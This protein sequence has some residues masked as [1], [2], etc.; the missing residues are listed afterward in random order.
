[1]EQSSSGQEQEHTRGG[2]D[3]APGFT[4]LQLV[5]ALNEGGVERGAIEISSAITAAGGRALVASAG[6]RLEQALRRAGGELIRLPGFDA[7]NPLKLPDFIRAIREI[8]LAEKVDIV[9]ARSRGPAWAG[10]FAARAEGCP[11]VTTY[12]GSYSEGFPGKRLYNSVMAK[13]RPVIAVSEFIAARVMERHGVAREDIVVIPRGADLEVFDE[14]LVTPQRTAAIT[15]DWEL[16][17]DPRPI[18]LLPGRLTRW[19]GQGLLVEAAALIAQGGRLPFRIVLAGGDPYGAFGREIEAQAQAA[20]LMHDV[21][22]VGSVTDMPAAL[23]LSAVVVCPSLEPEAFGRSVVEAQA[24][25]RPV[26]AANHG[27][28]RET[29]ADG[30]S[31]W[32]VPPGDAAALAGALRH[33]MALSGE[34]RARIGAAGLERVRA[35][36][37]I[38]AMQ[39]ATLEVYAEVLRRG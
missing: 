17:E 14:A 38:A 23:K 13:G 29:V 33:A 31:G 3:H 20:G 19:K 22:L 39:A 18:V 2:P 5:P 12:H 30:V 11:F 4:V 34:E 27:G 1:M 6:G 16:T 35:R 10:W 21:S 24:M 36:Y 25:S 8:I 32:L 9:H 28:A 37:S 7:K 15:A 26:I